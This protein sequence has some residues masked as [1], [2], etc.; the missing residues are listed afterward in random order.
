MLI[1]F[2]V[3]LL[4]VFIL[5]FLFFELPKKKNVKSNSNI[6]IYAE[7]N[8]KSESIGYIIKGE[9]EFVKDGKTLVEGTLIEFV[10]FNS[11]IYINSYNLDNTN[12]YTYNKKLIADNIMNRVVIKLENASDVLISH[13]GN[14]LND[15]LILNISSQL[16]RNVTI[17][18]RWSVCIIKLEINATVIEKPPMYNKYAKCYDLGYSLEN[19]EIHEIPLVIKS[20]GELKDEYIKIVLIDSDFRSS[21]YITEFEGKDVGGINKEY[22]ININNI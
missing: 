3:F 18:F 4:I 14:I 8:G 22:E 15:D 6:T 19:N 20:F 11:T 10:P 21:Q 7:Y 16:F 1:I 2:I 9:E 13:S 17:C 5:I 12:Y